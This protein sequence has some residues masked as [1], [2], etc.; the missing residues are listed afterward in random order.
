MGVIKGIGWFTLDLIDHYRLGS[1]ID[2][3]APLKFLPCHINTISRRPCSFY[4]YSSPKRLFPSGNVQ[5][6][7]WQSASD[8][9]CWW[10]R[11]FSKT[12]T[13][14]R[15]EAAFE[16]KINA[17][18]PFHQKKENCFLII[19]VCSPDGWSHVSLGRVKNLSNFYRSLRRFVYVPLEGYKYL[20][21]FRQS[22]EIR[23]FMKSLLCVSFICL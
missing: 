22:L 12:P 21:G 19:Y 17:I 1:S 4:K 20:H 16:K 7:L 10:E 13:K 8:R 6:R 15:I 3:L 14:V 9:H 18:V 2:T 23:H 11:R 5:D